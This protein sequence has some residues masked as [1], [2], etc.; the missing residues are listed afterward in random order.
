MGVEHPGNIG[1]GTVTSIRTRFCDTRN[2][3]DL[4]PGPAHRQFSELGGNALTQL[5][6]GFHPGGA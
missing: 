3:P 1:A 4:K 5:T 2:D 6:R